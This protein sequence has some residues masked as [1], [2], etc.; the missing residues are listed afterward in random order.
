M[1]SF[2]L[3][4]EIRFAANAF[5]LSLFAKIRNSD[6][7]AGA[8]RAE[9]RILDI[10]CG[11]ERYFREQ[12][13]RACKDPN[14]RERLPNK[15]VGIDKIHSPGTARR[16]DSDC[17]EFL[18]VDFFDYTPTSKFSIIYAS[19]AQSWLLAPRPGLSRDET[20]A[21]LAKKIFSML[22]ENGW[23]A[24]MSTSEVDNFPLY[25]RIIIECFM[26][27]GR[28]DLNYEQYIDA[29]QKGRYAFAPMHNIRHGEDIWKYSGFV[30]QLLLRSLEWIPLRVED[31]FF[32]YWE[33]GGQHLLRD[34]VGAEYESFTECFRNIVDTPATLNRLGIH[35]AT[36]ED[37]SR[38]IL[39]PV[40]QYYHIAQRQHHVKK[41]NCAGRADHGKHIGGS[42]MVEEVLATLNEVPPCEP[43]K[44]LRPVME[45]LKPIS[46]PIYVSV[47]Q[48][49]GTSQ[50]VTEM[51]R[52]DKEFDCRKA[53]VDLGAVLDLEYATLT[54]ALLGEGKPFYAG[55]FF[56]VQEASNVD[57][58]SD[59]ICCTSCAMN[60]R[61]CT[62]KFPGLLLLLPDAS[63]EA[64]RANCTESDK[65]L[66]IEPMSLLD[67]LI[68]VCGKASKSG[69][70]TWPRMLFN[71]DDA[72]SL[73]VRMARNDISERLKDEKWDWINP[74]RYFIWHAFVSC[75]DSVAG[76]VVPRRLKQ[77]VSMS[78]TGFAA[79][80][81]T[82]NGSYCVQYRYARLLLS[83]LSQ[84]ASFDLVD[85]A[86]REGVKEGGKDQLARQMRVQSHELLDTLTLIEP[87]MPEHVLEAVR[88]S[89]LTF[90]GLENL[91]K[92]S[93]EKLA[94]YGME[95]YGQGTTLAEIVTNA[96]K[97]AAEHAVISLNQI[98]D[99]Q[100]MD[101]SEFAT[102]IE[103][104][105][106]NVCLSQD[107]HNMYIA[108]HLETKETIRSRFLFATA[109]VAAMKNSFKH[110]RGVQQI[111]IGFD[112]KRL[113]V[114][115]SNS[116][117]YKSDKTKLTST[118]LT[119]QIL[120]E[121]YGRRNAA[122]FY[123][124]EGHNGENVCTACVPVPM[125]LI[126]ISTT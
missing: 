74:L 27:I 2:A 101:Q 17:C 12:W 19:F 81:P 3:T 57:S 31:E 5:F 24:S 125:G 69:H 7:G 67:P 36:G 126:D 21:L 63:L 102:E 88:R 85:L 53:L 71:S 89:L 34:I 29:R 42:L 86:E 50:G 47:V 13:Q 61:A 44:A 98:E 56:F 112:A 25:T 92:L 55:A 82:D 49:G 107:L 62:E 76:I 48:G 96:A 78:R 37:G 72:E 97:L 70:R 58:V 60:D 115:V 30:N 68:D 83:A 91:S 28:S 114:T 121:W 103:S 8:I 52:Y 14:G 117:K 104:Y 9:D 43:V 41:R 45:F 113:S 105:V 77:S 39:T 119:L 110:T 80:V 100:E 123:A 23:F 40:R 66:C 33:S 20:E 90:L 35:V 51:I 109:L 95:R 1:D 32:S 118:E 10:G 73:V 111:N 93:Q 22:D 46:R 120:A 122:G 116:G 65:G 75:P 15:I 87:A 94:S 124:E 11:P 108:A 79:W 4:E 99:L 6:Q 18:Q 84:Y 16:E 38:Y 59:F 26:Q 54:N 64:M 106:S